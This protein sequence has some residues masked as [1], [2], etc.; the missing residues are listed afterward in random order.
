MSLRP[1]HGDS[2]SSSQYYAHL[3]DFF[4]RNR[5]SYY[6]ALTQVRVTNDLLQWVRFFLNGVAHAATKGRKV[7]GQILTLRTI[8]E[9]RA[10][11]ADRTQGL[12]L[13]DYLLDLLKDEPELQLSGIFVLIKRRTVCFFRIGRDL[14]SMTIEHASTTPAI[15]KS[16]LS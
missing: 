3:S 11:P 1:K 12:G 9:K 4:E 15:Q 13:A 10:T 16:C 5:F 2:H 8:L 7:F 14:V 6:D